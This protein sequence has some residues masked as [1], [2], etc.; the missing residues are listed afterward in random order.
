MPSDI[1]PSDE[2][3]LGKKAPEHN[4]LVISPQHNPQTKAHKSKGPGHKPHKPSG[5]SPRC[6]LPDICL[7]AVSP[8]HKHPADRSSPMGYIVKPTNFFSKW[9]EI[10][11]E[12]I[13]AKLPR[14]VWSQTTA[15]T[16]AQG[17]KWKIELHCYL[18]W[19][20]Y[21]YAFLLENSV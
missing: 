15:Q 10:I 11:Q 16:T 17:I 6:N 3:P 1:S 13:N 9:R 14:N 19:V 20:F 12:I 8:R 2:S 21:D 7:L 5:H 4:P 18:S